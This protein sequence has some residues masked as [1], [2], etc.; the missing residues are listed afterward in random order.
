MKKRRSSNADRSPLSVFIFGIIFSFA[1]LTL[2]SFIS[3]LILLSIS[4]PLLSIK[5]TS[6]AVLLCAG[7][8]SGF[9]ISKY[10]GEM[11]LSIAVSAS[12]TVAVVMLGISLICAKGNVGGG[13]FMNYICYVL[14]S[15]LFAFLGRKRKVRHRHR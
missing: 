1:A 5:T 4:N 2:L 11:N 9:T 6:L 14:V 10:K 8:I 13:V 12:L 7:A 3:S 15:A